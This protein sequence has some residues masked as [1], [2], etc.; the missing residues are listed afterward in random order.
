MSLGCSVAFVMEE[1]SISSREQKR[2]EVLKRLESTLKKRKARIAVMEKF[3]R[4]EYK[5]QHGVEP[6]YVEFL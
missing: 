3:L 4:D 5:K 2:K 1:R 6:K